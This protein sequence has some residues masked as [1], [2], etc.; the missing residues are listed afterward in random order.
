[1]NKFKKIIYN[2]M[3]KNKM[4]Y[5]TN[6]LG[7]VIED[8]EKITCYVKKNKILKSGDYSYDID[9]LG[10]DN[11]DYRKK[12][13][14]AYNL[15]KPIC[16]VF[17][18]LEL[19]GKLSIYSGSCEVIIK[20]CSF[21]FGLFVIAGGKFTLDN[22]YININTFNYLSIY[23]NELVIK[24]MR[25]EQLKENSREPMITFDSHSKLDLIDSNIGNNEQR[26]RFCAID[27][28]N[29]V[30]SNVTGQ[31][32]ECESSKIN[33]D[34]KSSLTASNIV[35]LKTGDFNSLNITAPVITLNGEKLENE[36]G[37]GVFRKSTDS[38]EL[39]RSELISLLKK[40]KEQ[41]ESINTKEVSKYEEMQKAKP[42]R[43]IL[44]VE[45]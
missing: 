38:L 42:I 40:L 24:N 12:I 21:D 17:D 45:K 8:D 28:L 18:G 43:K 41:C 9:C 5:L 39:R 11:D 22:T 30:N 19:R 3:R 10:I 27:T 13:A 34:E 1:M 20:N 25:S 4:N 15:D 26:F 37:K 2:I 7:E 16:Y 23:A 29:I 35:S 14:K 44:K 6:N 33:A 31:E 36:N 32:I